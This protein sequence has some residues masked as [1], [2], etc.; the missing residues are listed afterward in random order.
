MPW[1]RKTG[2][3]GR[4]KPFQNFWIVNTCDD[5]TEAGW[6]A[7]QIAARYSFADF[8]DHDIYGG[9]SDILTIGLNWYWNPNSRLQFNYLHGQI[10]NSNTS[11]AAMSGGPASGNFNSF[12]ARFMVDF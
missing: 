5:C 3:L 7:W 2:Q 9:Q 4:P 8:N 6:G 10:S 11:R 12:G 1:D